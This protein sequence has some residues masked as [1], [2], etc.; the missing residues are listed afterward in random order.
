[1]R[2]LDSRLEA[3]SPDSSI[4]SQNGK[5]NKINKTPL[6]EALPTSGTSGVSGTSGE[7]WTNNPRSETASL[8][9]SIAK[10]TDNANQ[11][12]ETSKSYEAETKKLPDNFDAKHYA[13]KS[14]R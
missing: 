12:I 14:L 11:A 9:Q 2:P 7:V 1:M 3:N 4:I 10:N 8:S 6:E 13:T 5:N